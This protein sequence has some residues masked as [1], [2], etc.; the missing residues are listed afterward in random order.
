MDGIGILMAQLMDN[1]CYPVVVLGGEGI[2]DEA[3]ELECPA[4]APIV[5]LVVEG[6]CDVGVHGE[7]LSRVQDNSL[8]YM[9][10]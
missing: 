7:G 5:E 6:F 4:L 10:Q 3:L 2:A 8:V 9:A 1:P